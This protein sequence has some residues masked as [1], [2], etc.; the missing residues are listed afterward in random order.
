MS[1]PFWKIFKKLFSLYFCFIFHILSYP[2]FYNISL[3]W[4]FPWRSKSA[5]LPFFFSF[6]SFSPC[7]CSHSLHFSQHFFTSL[8][9]YL[10][11]F[12][13]TFRCKN[14][15]SVSSA[16][17]LLQKTRSILIPTR[18]FS[19]R[20][21]LWPICFSVFFRSSFS[22]NTPVPFCL[23]LSLHHL[24][25]VFSIFSPSKALTADGSYVLCFCFIF[26]YPLPKN[27]FPS[28]LFVSFFLFGASLSIFFCEPFLRFL[29]SFFPFP[30]LF[31]Y[32]SPKNKSSVLRIFWGFGRFREETRDSPIFSVK[33][34]D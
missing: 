19:A 7:L 34:L 1:I 3:F 21:V 23:P 31:E 11:H 20:Q 18:S 15:R 12:F 32:F 25:L 24:L 33:K 30:F 22:N 4:R 2:I 16:S 14:F 9:I 29:S 27:C 28:Y 6:P 8:D 5:F 26:L 13:F 10:R 17:V